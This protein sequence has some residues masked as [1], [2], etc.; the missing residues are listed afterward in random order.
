VDFSDG[1]VSNFYKSYKGYVR[2][3]NGDESQPSLSD[4]GDRT[5]TDDE[6][7]LIWQQDEGGNM[8][9]EAALA[10]CEELSL[11]G[12]SDWRLPNK[13]ELQSIIDYTTTNPSS[14][15]SFF[16]ATPSQYWSSTT[17]AA[18]SNRAW[19]A[20]FGYGSLYYYEKT[21][22]HDVRCVKG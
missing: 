18:N 21:S 22:S 8:T 15:S 6:T 20:Y 11:A 4:N 7:K 14:N 3:V 12:F 13:N 2:C 16:S 10:Y 17:Y 5:I 9:W 19:S 1:L